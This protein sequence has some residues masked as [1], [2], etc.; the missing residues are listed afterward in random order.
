MFPGDSLDKD[1]RDAEDKRR[2]KEAIR[3]KS[4]RDRRQE[5]LA[6]EHNR[7][8]EQRRK[9][10]RRLLEDRRVTS[11]WSEERLQ[12]E[13]LRMNNRIKSEKSFIIFA[14]AVSFIIFL[15]FLIIFK[16]IDLF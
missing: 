10:E 4:T 6:V 1:R 15:C 12:E 16:D 9:G 13:R 3:R 5:T 11:D 8:K 14:I 7:R 2:R